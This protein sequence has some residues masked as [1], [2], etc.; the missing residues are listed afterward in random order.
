MLYQ[1]G[2]AFLSFRNLLHRAGIGL[3]PF[4]LGCVGTPYGFAAGG[5]AGMGGV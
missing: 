1:L 3:Q 2:S 4:A 5:H